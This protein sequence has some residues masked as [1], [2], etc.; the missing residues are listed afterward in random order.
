MKD[1]EISVRFKGKCL[2]F[3]N[4]NDLYSSNKKPE[5]EENLNSISNY[6]NDYNYLF[7]DENGNFLIYSICKNVF[8]FAES[9]APQENEAYI[10]CFQKFIFVSKIDFSFYSFSF[11][12]EKLP[13]LTNFSVDFAI[14]EFAHK[15][16]NFLL[17]LF[18]YFILFYFF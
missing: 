13:I 14:D 1:T 8:F 12:G 18:S 2:N 15:R 4:L 17:N 10:R 9:N 3:H 5:I 11:S 16:V 6:L 7:K